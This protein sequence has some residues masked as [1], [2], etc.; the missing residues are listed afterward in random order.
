VD[1]PLMAA[2]LPAPSSASVIRAVHALRGQEGARSTWPTA[3]RIADHLR[4][5]E[6]DVLRHLR[7]LRNQRIFTERQRRGEKVWMPW[8]EA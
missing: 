1:D 7:S 4:A 5:D 8:D 2:K 6:A 3:K